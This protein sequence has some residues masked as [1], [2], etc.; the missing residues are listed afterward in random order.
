MTNTLASRDGQ[1][2]LSDWIR[3]PRCDGHLYRCLDFDEVKLRSCIVNQLHLL[4]SLGLLDASF[5]RYLLIQGS[6]DPLPGYHAFLVCA[7]YYYL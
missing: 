2:M 5:A 3:R 4:F 6:L 1:G 7:P